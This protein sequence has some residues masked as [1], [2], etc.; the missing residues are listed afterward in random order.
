MKDARQPSQGPGLSLPLS[1]SIA[2]TPAL[3]IYHITLAEQANANAM[4]DTKM[5]QLNQSQ[6]GGNRNYN[7]LQTVFYKVYSTFPL[8]IL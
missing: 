7:C 8:I 5:A 4:Q 1:S 3:S 6:R 2:A